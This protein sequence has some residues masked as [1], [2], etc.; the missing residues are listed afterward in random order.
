MEDQI[1]SQMSVL[2]RAHWSYRKRFIGEKRVCARVSP[3]S[4]Y[5]G[6]C[7]S[8]R[9][10]DAIIWLRRSDGPPT[11]RRVAGEPFVDEHLIVLEREMEHAFQVEA[12]PAGRSIIGAIFPAGLRQAVRERLEALVRH[13]PVLKLEGGAGTKVAANAEAIEKALAAHLDGRASGAPG[14]QA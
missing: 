7:E 14:G 10:L 12:T 8:A 3:A 6:A 9:P 1:W 11:V 5:A 4:I 2:R 13:T